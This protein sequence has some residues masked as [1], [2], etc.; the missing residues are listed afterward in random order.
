MCQDVVFSCPIPDDGWL[1]ALQI[2][3]GGAARLGAT[4][5]DAFHDNP[6]FHSVYLAGLDG[7]EFRFGTQVPSS[8]TAKSDC[9]IV[10]DD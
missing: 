7:M 9:R 8:L 3:K 6:G 1:R 10:T 5:Y 2:V 4:Y